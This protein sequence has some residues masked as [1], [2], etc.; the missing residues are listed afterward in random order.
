MSNTPLAY[1]VYT[2]D[3]IAIGSNTYT[4]ASVNAASNTITT[5]SNVVTGVSN[6]LMA[7]SRTFV[8]GGSL[9][10]MNNIIIY[11]TIEQ[12]YIANT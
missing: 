1:I 9:S 5:T 8:A 10:N 4:V 11:N 6:S 2:G 12:Q 7:V 3:T